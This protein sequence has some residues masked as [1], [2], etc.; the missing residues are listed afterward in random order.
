MSERV[1]IDV[2]L[3]GSEQVHQGFQKIGASSQHMGK[4][5][6]Q[7]SRQMRDLVMMAPAVGRLGQA[8]GILTDEQSRMVTEMASLVSVA[9]YMGRGLRVL[10]DLNLKAAAAT[11]AK[12]AATVSA[13]VATWGHV[14]AE[15]ARAAAHAVAHALSG[16]AGWAILAG[17]AAA[18]G[19]GLALLHHIPER[20][21]GG[22][23][24]ED[25]MYYLRAGEVVSASQV[26]DMFEA[27]TAQMLN[28]PVAPTP[29]V[30][31]QQQQVPARHAGGAIPRDGAYYLRAGEVYNTNRTTNL[32]GVNIHV[33]GGRVD[34]V[35]EALRR[36]GVK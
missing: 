28:L 32:G 31:A 8:F 16:P 25:G 19:G 6:Y 2:A 7:A 3:H 34:D 18:V 29:A 22:V 17:A 5:V 26:R 11:A 4:E 13:T 20:H 30:V 24:P 10:I 36:V 14:A 33:H 21:T 15:K 12:T 35:L 27:V 23:V 9:Y 1:D